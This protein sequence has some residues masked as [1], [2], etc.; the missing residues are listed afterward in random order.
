MVFTLQQMVT[1]CLKMESDTV[2]SMNDDLIQNTKDFQWYCQQH[3]KHLLDFILS[4]TKNMRKIECLRNEVQAIC[5]TKD[6]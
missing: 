1:T 5:R 3:P 4:A 6:N 2:K